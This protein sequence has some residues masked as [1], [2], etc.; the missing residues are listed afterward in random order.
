M[1]DQSLTTYVEAH[2]TAEAEILQRLNRHTH[3]HIL[4]PRMLSGHLQGR[5]LAM[6][7]KMIRP[8]AILEIG[9][10]TG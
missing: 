1:L 8:K 5:L 2:T 10:Y 9:T 7:S 4:K 3:A 6:F